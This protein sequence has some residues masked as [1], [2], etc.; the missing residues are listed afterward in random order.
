MTERLRLLAALAFAGVLLGACGS[1]TL[2]PPASSTTAASAMSSATAL[3]GGW[4]VTNASKATVTVREQLV[5]LTLPSDA[6]LTATGASGSFDVKSDGTFAPGSEITFDLTTLQSDQAQRDNF[7]KQTTLQ[8]RQYPTATFVPTKATGLATPLQASG[9]FTFTLRGDLTIHG[10]TKQVNFDVQAKR[11]GG[12]LTA[13]ATANPTLKF[14]D[15]G[16]TP[17]SVPTRVLSVTD[18]IRL[19]VALVANGP[20]S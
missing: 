8:T 4:T 15:F 12:T 10:T 16:M 13:T 3:L 2:A 7:I 1:E 5:N 20:A 11:D 14:E 9:T 6:V 19:V 17:P 18:D